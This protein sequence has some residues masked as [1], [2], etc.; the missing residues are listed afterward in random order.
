MESVDIGRPG[1]L[2]K[3]AN[4][5]DIA[6]WTSF[7]ED[8]QEARKVVYDKAIPLSEALGRL[9]NLARKYRRKFSRRRNWLIDVNRLVSRDIAHTYYARGAPLAVRR[10]AFRNQLRYGFDVPAEQ[11]ASMETFVRYC[12]HCGDL[13]EAE[14]EL[15]RITATVLRSRKLRRDKFVLMSLIELFNDFFEAEDKLGEILAPAPIVEGDGP[16]AADPGSTN[17]AV[18]WEHFFSEWRLVH[19]HGFYA[20]VSLTEGLALLRKL[21]TKYRRKF[22]H[23]RRWLTEINRVISRDIAQLNSWRSASLAVRRRAYRTQLTHGFGAPAERISAMSSFASS[24]IRLGELAEAEK[25]ITAMAA[26]VVGSRALRRDKFVLATSMELFNEFLEA[27][28]KHAREP[29]PG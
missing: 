1:V 11:I 23:H 25:E 7:F 20:T 18:E 24:C 5:S 22:P 16:A 27:E 29:L 15:T 21:A 26:V 4:A 3:E 9:R 28:E 10:R 6:E 8:W 12:I 2:M 17:H 14:I 13:A 19:S